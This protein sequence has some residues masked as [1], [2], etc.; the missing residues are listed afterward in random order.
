MQSAIP[1]QLCIDGKTLERVESTKFLG[2]MIDSKLNWSNHINHVTLKI[3]KGLGI[4]GRLRNAL[5]LHILLTLYYTLIY[6]Y[7]SYC[8]II[9]GCASATLLR[10]LIV[11]QMRSMR[12][13]TSSPYLSVESFVS[14]ATFIKT[15]GYL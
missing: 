3:S 11:L 5:P 10:K 13:I 9:W 8:N 14:T 7:L 15:D 1:F 4:I 2:I 6:P 12:I